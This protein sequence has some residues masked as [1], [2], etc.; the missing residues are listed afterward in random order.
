[1]DEL[2]LAPSPSGS[3]AQ[4][5]GEVVEPVEVE[6]RSSSKYH[7]WKRRQQRKTQRRRAA[8]ARV[9]PS[10]HGRPSGP[11]HGVVD[12]LRFSG[13]GRG[14]G[15][16]INPS[17][18]VGSVRGPFGVNQ[19]LGTRGSAPSV[20]ADSVSN[21]YASVVERG[22]VACVSAPSMDAGSTTG[23]SVIASAPSAEAD[24]DVGNGSHISVVTEDV[25]IVSAPSAEADLGVGNGSHIP[26][27][28]KDADMS[29]SSAEVVID[30]PAPVEGAEAPR[31]EIEP[32]ESVLDPV[33]VP[34]VEYF[35]CYDSHF[36]PDRLETKTSKFWNG[37]PLA[38][39]RMPDRRILL[40]GGVMNFCDPKK[41][42]SPL[43]ERN[44]E[45]DPKF[46][47]AVG[48]H[49]KRAHCYRECE[50]EA[51]LRLLNHPRV[52]AISEVGLDFTRSPTDWRHQE[53]LL[54]R[55]LELG[56]YGFVLLMHLWGALVDPLG[57]VVHHLSRRLLR[58]YCTRHQRIHLH[59]FAGDEGA[60]RAWMHEFPNCYFGFTGLV[61]SF[62][63]AQRRALRVIPAE[64]LLLETDSPHL[65][66]HP[67][68]NYNT[69]LYIADLG[70]LVADARGD[71]LS[72]LLVA[73][74]MNGQRLY[75]P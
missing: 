26:V 38:P 4:E 66:I 30:G 73:T 27:T 44:F 47:M 22:Y 59:C 14:R 40:A 25:V 68:Q 70:Q 53:D 71:V 6:M 29:T 49:P 18:V 57:G 36:H 15:R 52:V 41:F 72:D 43:F 58:R 54:N 9:V 42:L 39:G 69:P 35:V 11:K 1:M 17:L 48:I 19:G 7:T 23:T 21:T 51:F 60:A 5:V 64:R 65:K 75:G 67:E 34:D 56:T 16:G 10:F 61:R 3:L 8:E 55:V 63:A 50:W 28:T 46:K 32:G 12:S 62:S 24:R 20:E 74:C 33:I 37:E 13:G 2:T 45:R 31:T